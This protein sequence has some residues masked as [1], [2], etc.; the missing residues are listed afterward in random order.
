LI[1]SIGDVIGR[2]VGGDWLGMA[3][4]FYPMG[5]KSVRDEVVPSVF[6]DEGRFG[7]ITR[8]AKLY[9]TTRA[10]VRRWED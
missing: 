1:E 4:T 9:S 6:G 3:H 7:S 2:R 5:L 10:V 8:S